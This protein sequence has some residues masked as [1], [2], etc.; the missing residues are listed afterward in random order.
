VIEDGY[1]FG[2]DYDRTLLAWYDNFEFS[3]HEISEK[4]GERSSR[5]ALAAGIGR[6]VPRPSQ[7][8][9]ARIMSPHGVIMVSRSVDVGIRAGAT[10]ARQ[11][12]R[13]MHCCAH[14]FTLGRRPNGYRRAYVDRTA[15]GR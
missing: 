4:Y 3:W 13:A 8:A 11:P 1:S 5:G 2:A 9:V 7:P 14:T 6:G 10:G 15:G 12:V